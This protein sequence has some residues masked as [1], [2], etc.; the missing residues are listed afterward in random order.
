MAA[1]KIFD[2]K[3]IVPPKEPATTATEATEAKPKKPKSRSALNP[4]K[5]FGCRFCDKHYVSQQGAM[6]HE[7]KQHDDQRRARDLM[8]T[9]ARHGTR[10]YTEA[11]P[12]KQPDPVKQAKA[13]TRK[14][15]KEK[16]VAAVIMDAEPAPAPHAA[17]KRQP[18]P[19]HQREEDKR[20]LPP[21][22]VIAAPKTAKTVIAGKGGKW[23]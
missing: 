14:K 1:R 17:P 10:E 7:M 8:E 12:A 13:E 23:F 21:P 15:E 3:E 19:V 5:P 22:P 20:P 6:I 16:A 9:L 4:N 11:M 2:V 18:S